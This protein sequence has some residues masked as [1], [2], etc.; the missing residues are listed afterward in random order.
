KAE[1]YPVPKRYRTLTPYIVAKN[2][3]AEIEFVKA[4]FDAEEMFRSVGGAGGRH[5][6]VRLG[7]SMMMIG[8][9][10]PGLAWQG[11]L[12]PGAFHVYVRDCDAIHKRGLQAGD[13]SIHEPTG[14]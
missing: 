14:H 7:D 8:G 13:A 12:H 1:V 4:T 5:C 2:A 6:E 10:G 9:G 11:D 3:D